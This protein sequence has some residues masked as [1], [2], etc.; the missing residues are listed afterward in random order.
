MESKTTLEEGRANSYRPS[1]TLYSQQRTL[2]LNRKKNLRKKKSHSLVKS[3]RFLPARVTQ[4][5]NSNR[6]MEKRKSKKAELKKTYK[7]EWNS[8][9]CG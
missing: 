6:R 3:T 9:G 4:R 2:D 8:S 7:K 5:K 1:V